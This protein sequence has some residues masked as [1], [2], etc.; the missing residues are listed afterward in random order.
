MGQE[1]HVSMGPI[2]ARKTFQI[3]KN[4]EKILAIEMI[5]AAQAIDLRRPLQSS[6]ILE[7]CH[8]YIRK[9]IPHVAED[10]V[11]SELIE[12]SLEIIRSKELLKLIE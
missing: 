4:L 7:A 11:L 8:A 5:C 9:K 6:E 10:I 1:D 3:V 12:T 2:S